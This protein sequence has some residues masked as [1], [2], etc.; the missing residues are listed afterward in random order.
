MLPALPERNLVF[1]GRATDKEDVNK[2]MLTPLIRY[3]LQGGSAL[4][5][6]EKAEGKSEKSAATGRR[7]GPRGLPC[8]P[9]LAG[10]PWPRLSQAVPVLAKPAPCKAMPF[11]QGISCSVSRPAEPPG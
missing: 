1:K 3:P 5:T 2:L 8:I 7:P 11:S 9:S 4:I 10:V 6:F